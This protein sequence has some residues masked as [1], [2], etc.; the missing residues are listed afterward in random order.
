[1]GVKEKQFNPFNC[2]PWDQRVGGTV[3]LIS[4]LVKICV[5]YSTV[6]YL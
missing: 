6:E 3:N 2:V 4:H 5:V 1:M